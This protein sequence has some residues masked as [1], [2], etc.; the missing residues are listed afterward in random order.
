M[1]KLR[2]EIEDYDSKNLSQYLQQK[3][4]VSSKTANTLKENLIDGCSFF[5][6]SRDDLKE[7][8]IPLH[9]RKINERLVGITYQ[10]T[11][12]S[13]RTTSVQFFTPV[14]LYLQPFS[15]V[16][17]SSSRPSPTSVVPASFSPGGLAT[18]ISWIPSVLPESFSRRTKEALSS[19]F[20]TKSARIE[21]C[22][23]L[24]H[25]VYAITEYP[26]SQEY[27]AVCQALVLKYPVLKD[28]L[29]NGFVSLWSRLHTVIH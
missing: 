1:S 9:D 24:A 4:K 11:T 16:S 18:G 26:T 19:K 12:S 20:I 23:M 2:N 15:E 8:Q 14:F 7:L 3:E 29:G 13:V 25:K 5:E 28:T 21:I 22:D 10:S 17:P 27:N 6:I